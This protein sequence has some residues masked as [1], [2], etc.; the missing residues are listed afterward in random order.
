VAGGDFSGEN[1][2]QSIS[3]IRCAVCITA[4]ST[5]TTLTPLPDTSDDAVG[6]VISNKFYIL[7]GHNSAGSNMPP[8]L[9]GTP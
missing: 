8:V 3:D 9:I 5:V 4:A 6:G 1:S 7:G 2:V